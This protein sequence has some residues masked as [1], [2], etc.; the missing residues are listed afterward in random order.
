MSKTFSWILF[1][2]LFSWG[3]NLVRNPG[4]EDNI[5][6][7]GASIFLTNTKHWSPVDNHGGTPD[8]YLKDC[9]YNGIVNNQM[10]PGQAPKLGE[11]F[12]GMFCGGDD[13]REYCT[14]ELEKELVAGVVY[15][16]E[17]WIRPAAGYGTAINSFGA[18]FSKDP[19]KG[20]GN[21]RVLRL[22]SHIGFPE[23]QILNDYEQWFTVKGEYT[24]IGGEKYLT[25][26]NFKNDAQTKREVIKQACIRPD[27]SYVLLDEVSVTAKNIQP[28][29]P[30]DTI[31]ETIRPELK[32]SVRDVFY[33][34]SKNIKLEIWDNNVED[35]DSVRIYLDDQII[36]NEIGITKK[37]KTFSQ[38]LSE[39]NSVL[40]IQALN[41]GSR[42]PNTLA[43]RISDGINTKQMVISTDLKNAQALKII[44]KD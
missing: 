42:P 5:G 25:L 31:K 7:P 44:L 16:V 15:S 17:Y 26:G 1:V 40:I 43:L 12:I 37:A 32:Y 33:A 13:L 41:L 23:D 38:L 22:T 35:G 24:A 18:H 2:P 19:V 34:K 14:T 4:F 10:A 27:R 30:L 6:C 9:P 36:E 3:Q 29:Q 39:Q 21:L 20:D 11:G 28:V 8:L